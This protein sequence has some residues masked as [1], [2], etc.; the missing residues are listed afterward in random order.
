MGI[1][2][3]HYSRQKDCALHCTV[4]SWVRRRD[5]PFTK[6]GLVQLDRH[7]T[8]S[9]YPLMPASVFCSSGSLIIA[10][11]W[12]AL[13]KSLTNQVRNLLFFAPGVEA[14][15]HHSGDLYSIFD[16]SIHFNTWMVTH[17][18][19]NHGTSCLTSVIQL[20]KAILLYQVGNTS[21]AR[22]L[23]LSNLGPSC[24]WTWATIQVDAVVKNTVKSE[25]QRN[26]VSIT[27]S[28][29]KNC[30]L[31]TLWLHFIRHQ[32]VTFLSTS[33]LPPFVPW[34]LFCPRT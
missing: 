16:Y 12:S 30:S 27:C 33:N 2:C 13:M 24:T 10:T 17:P 3:V 20:W 9:T 4:Y 23:K 28:W 25:E 5:I 8:L 19:S 18:S 34:T 26:R 22:S 21:P 32:G 29:G 1:Q 15:L 7:S 14:P 6:V 11:R 31:F